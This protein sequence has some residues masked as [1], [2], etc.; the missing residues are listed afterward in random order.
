MHILNIHI[1]DAISWIWKIEDWPN[2]QTN[3][4]EEAE[5]VN[6]Y[7]MSNST[8]LIIEHCYMLPHSKSIA[9]RNPI[10]KWMQLNWHELIS[11]LQ[12]MFFIL[13]SNNF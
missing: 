6:I 8:L 7:E 3:N 9:T 4:V 12:H 1:Y 5:C 2:K 13:K 10:L 11:M